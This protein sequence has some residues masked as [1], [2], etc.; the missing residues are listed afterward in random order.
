MS[1]EL[2]VPQSDLFKRMLDN[3][4]RGRI[5]PTELDN[6]KN[7]GALRRQ[8]YC[9]SC[10]VRVNMTNVD[11]HPFPHMLRFGSRAH[12]ETHDRNIAVETVKTDHENCIINYKKTMIN[13]TIIKQRQVRS[14]EV[15]GG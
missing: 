13:E 11:R 15:S 3:R 7:G 4:G 14:E 5:T 1:E 2:D 12:C 10:G 9:E 8:L 6:L